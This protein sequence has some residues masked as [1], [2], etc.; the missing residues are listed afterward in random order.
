MLHI[1]NGDAMV[2]AFDA[3]A[4]PGERLVWRE[5]LIAGPVTF[6]HTK[7][8]I[9]RRAEH[10]ASAYG[11]DPLTCR[12]DLEAQEMGLLHALEN[13]REIVLWFEADLFC[14]L[15]LI[16][17]LFRID[18]GRKGGVVPRVTLVSARS[19]G[20]DPYAGFGRMT[21]EELGGMFTMRER[22]SLAPLRLGC[23]AWSMYAS[24]YP[25]RI[26]HLLEEG[27]DGLK[28]LGPALRA[29]LARFPSTENGLGSIQQ[30]ALELIADGAIT[31]GDLFRAFATRLPLYGLGDFQFW[32][33]LLPL[34]AGPRPLLVAA[35]I[36]SPRRA[37]LEGTFARAEVRLTPLGAAVLAGRED[38]LRLNGIDC[39][40]G[41]VHLRPGHPLWRW[42]RR[43]GRLVGGED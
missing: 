8:W 27:T 29:H 14:Q 41:G 7:A 6:L 19:I 43:A 9:E 17:I 4:L 12:R 32:N 28:D 10:L 1:L 23:A 15:H 31:F 30:G 21:S 2:K 39:W 20:E 26:E 5:A 25:L 34:I 33:E 13:G 24:D 40:L 37:L 16:Y 36:G 38:A 35:G 42:D 3:A 11:A 22:L 18:A